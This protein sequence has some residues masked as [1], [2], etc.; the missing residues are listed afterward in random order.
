M[1]MQP[2]ALKRLGLLEEDTPF[3][4]QETLPTCKG[5]EYERRIGCNSDNYVTYIWITPVVKT[6]DNSDTNFC[7][8][9][10]SAIDYW[11]PIVAD[12][13]FDPVVIQSFD[14]PIID[15]FL[16]LRYLQAMHIKVQSSPALAGTLPLQLAGLTDM[17]HLAI[18]YTCMTGALPVA[19]EW[20]QLSTLLVGALGDGD[21]PDD[22]QTR[23]SPECGLSGSLPASWPQ[24]MPRL[25]E[26]Y[27]VNNDLEGSLPRSLAQWHELKGLKLSQNKLSSSIPSIYA[28][29]AITDLVLRSNKLFGRLPSFELTPRK[30]FSPLQRS[31]ENMDLSDNAF[32]GGFTT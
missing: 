5:A 12:N 2:R 27:L 22:L 32:T 11:G 14:A 8:L 19:W 26:L 4:H 3:C 25:K 31:L 18:T 15:A 7:F 6:I 30:G 20:P 1:F 17:K 24:Q 23:V 13:L 10:G 29:L 28:Q 9:K 21:G 16:T